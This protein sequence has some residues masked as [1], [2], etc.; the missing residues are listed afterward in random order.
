MGLFYVDAH[1]SYTAFS[2]NK[3]IEH[4]KFVANKGQR[5]VNKIYHVQNV[6]N[7]AKRL[8]PYNG[9]ATK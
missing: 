1:L 3:N 4:H 7:T 9:V 8:L 5:A 2:R 6:N